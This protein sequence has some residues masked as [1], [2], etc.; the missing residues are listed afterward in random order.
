MQAQWSGRRI[1][2]RC[3]VPLAAAVVISSLVLCALAG[4]DCDHSPGVVPPNS[5]PYGHSY[6]E[7]SARHW[8]WCYSMPVGDSWEE[9]DNG[10]YTH[11][12]FL[13]QISDLSEG[14]TSVDL[15]YG[16]PN[17]P[18]W[19]LGGTVF[20][21]GVPGGPWYGYAKRQG[22]VPFGKALF[23]PILD[24]EQSYVESWNPYVDSSGNVFPG[25]DDTDPNALRAEA[26]SFFAPTSMACEI[27]GVPVKHLS[28][29]SP[30][31]VESP[32]FR[33]G[34][35]PSVSIFEL[36]GVPDDLIATLTS[37]GLPTPPKS[38]RRFALGAAQGN[39]TK[40]VSDGSFIML[41]PLPLGH[42]IIH[43]SGVVGVAD[44]PGSFNLDIT[45][46]ITV[47]PE[48]HGHGHD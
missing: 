27:D 22:T 3:F 40:S 37:E 28:L 33:I 17:G 20:P 26:E 7:W 18:V 8:Q 25:S 24:C 21:T 47:V 15:S 44:Q 1:A 45:Y 29:P 23:F 31:H 9:V 43:F 48:R 13:G 42:H 30:Y 39:C 5:N 16:Q 34:P 2:T 14:F 38:I 36:F 4:H 10:T 19:F 6:G 41:A 32:L 12:L 35:F 11:P 46:K